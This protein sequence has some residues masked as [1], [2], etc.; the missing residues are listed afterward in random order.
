MSSLIDI[1]EQK[2][3]LLV[4]YMPVSKV[5][6]LFLKK[7]QQIKSKAENQ[8]K[9][10]YISIILYIFQEK[11]IAKRSCKGSYQNGIHLFIPPRIDC[12]CG[13]MEL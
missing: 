1:C 9:G 6:L 7:P 11:P 8:S 13:W 5:C 12:L 2:V 4:P 10:K 3:Q